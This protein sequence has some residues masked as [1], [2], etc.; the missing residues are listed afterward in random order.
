MSHFLTHN[1]RTFL[2]TLGG[3]SLLSFG[4][5]SACGFR[6]RGSVTIPYKAILISGRP[7]PQLRYDLERIIV[8]GSNAKVVSSG[9]D[10]DLILE[11]VSEESTR[12]ILTYTSTGQISAYRLNNRVIFRAF[13][14]VGAEIIPESD[15]YVTRDL[16]FTTATVLASDVQQQQFLESMRADLA[17]QILRRVA[18][19][20][21]VTR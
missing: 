15:I 6:L 13:D 12:Q 8:T 20:G 4:G 21:R 17:L 7:S 5:L 19:L 2:K 18:T 16:D 1:R 10:A 3:I 14:N 11:I 9:K